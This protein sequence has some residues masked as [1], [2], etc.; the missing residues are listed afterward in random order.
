MKST[1]KFLIGIVVGIVLLV[2]I[3]FAIALL[4]PEA[5][6]RAE[7][8]PEGVTHNYLLAL[9]KEDMERA[10]GY[11]SP[12]L[13][14]YP[15]SVEAFAEDVESDSYRFRIDRDVT[16]MV[17]SADVTG[18]RAV[19]DVRESRFRSGDLFEPSPRTIIFEIELR[20]EGGEWKIVESKY[21]FSRCWTDSDISWCD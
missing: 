20:L 9:Q 1:D 7:D 14:G 19:V 13:D 3:A 16:L 4:R 18:G 8:S 5:A 21:Y 2:V 17:E 11:L 12:T 10:Y 6:Y 15:E